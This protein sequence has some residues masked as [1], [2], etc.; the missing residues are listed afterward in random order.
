MAR[1]HRVVALRSLLRDPTLPAISSA[2]GAVPRPGRYRWLSYFDAQIRF[3]E[4]FVVAMLEDAR[5]AGGRTWR[6]VRWTCHRAIR[7]TAVEIF[8]QSNSPLARARPGGV[9]NATGAWVVET[10][11]RLAVSGG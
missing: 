7:G 3:P 6:P 8:D 1:A 5:R 11:E 4:R 2:G 9:V 10:L